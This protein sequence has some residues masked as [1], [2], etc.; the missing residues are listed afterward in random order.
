[1]F[2]FSIRQ[3]VFYRCKIFFASGGLLVDGFK[4]FPR[5]AAD[6]S[7]VE[8]VEGDKSPSPKFATTLI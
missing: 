6:V 7:Y 2:K 8:G 1:M 4:G 5:D 3:V